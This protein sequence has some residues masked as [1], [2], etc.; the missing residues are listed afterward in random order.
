MNFDIE[1]DIPVLIDRLQIAIEE[2]ENEELKVLLYD[3]MNAIVALAD[4]SVNVVSTD[5]NVIMK[6]SDEQVR[7]ILAQVIDQLIKD[8]IAGHTT[9]TDEEQLLLPFHEEEK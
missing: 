4:M 2:T 7:A 9:K 8:I 5:G 1:E 3:A 6:V